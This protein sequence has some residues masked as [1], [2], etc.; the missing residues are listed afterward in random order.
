MFRVEFAVHIQHKR[1]WM[2]F[3]REEQLPFA[4]F[5]GLDILDDA[6]GQ[7]TLRHVAWHSDS[8]MF[9]C[10]GQKEMPGMT[11]KAITALMEKHGWTED[12]Q[13]RESHPV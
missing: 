5:I 13:A 4:P 3:D 11:M 2:T 7:F 1:G 8:R 12:R 9:L 10:Q 6:L